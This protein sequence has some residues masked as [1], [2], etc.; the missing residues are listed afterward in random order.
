MCMRLRCIM[1][2]DVEF[3]SKSKRITRQGILVGLTSVGLYWIIFLD[4]GAFN[5]G[6]YAVIQVNLF[7]QFPV[8]R[9]LYW[10]HFWR[11][12]IGFYSICTQWKYVRSKVR[13]IRKEISCFWWRRP[14]NTLNM[15]FWVKF[16]RNTPSM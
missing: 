3:I 13:L 1:W 7:C 6:K 2:F 9:I 10:W 8:N 11:E 5:S 4:Y 15:L 16:P 12:N 14:Q